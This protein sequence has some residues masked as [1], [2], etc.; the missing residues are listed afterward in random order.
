MPDI[1]VKIYLDFQKKNSVT[2]F[3][4]IRPEGAASIHTELTKLIG[5]F[6]D[7]ASKPKHS[8]CHMHEEIRNIGR[9]LVV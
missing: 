8:T 4:E 7:Y 3:T 6:R 9:L 1:Y 2:N 5:A